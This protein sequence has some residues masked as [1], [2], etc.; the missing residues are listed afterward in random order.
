[1]WP[2]L[3]RSVLGS[4]HLLFVMHKL[5]AFLSQ[6]PLSLA[7]VSSEDAAGPG[8]VLRHLR[9]WMVPLPHRFQLGLVTTQVLAPGPLCVLLI[10]HSISENR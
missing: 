1:M 8:A 2:L 7:V 3:D 6:K 5:K 9:A 10:F 4:G